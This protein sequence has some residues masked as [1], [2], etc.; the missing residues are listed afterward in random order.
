MGIPVPPDRLL[1]EADLAAP[2]FRCGQ[3]G[4]KWRH[5]SIVWPHA[6]FAVAAAARLNAPAEYGFRFECSGYRQTAVTAQP[7]DVE[8]NTPLPARAGRWAAP[9]AGG[10]PPRLE[11]RP[12]PVPALRSRIHR[13][14]SGL[15]A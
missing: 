10:V 13:G 15:A 8:A 6:L 12:V 5:I 11:G 1:L 4:G 14:P 7:W 9:R 2:E 3:L